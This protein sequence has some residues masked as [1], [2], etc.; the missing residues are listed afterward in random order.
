MLRGTSLHFSSSSLILRN[1]CGGSAPLRR[2]PNQTMTDPIAETRRWIEDAVLG[3]GL[4]PFAT[5]PWSEDAVHFALTDATLL[6]DVVDSALAEVA[7]LIDK[8][9]KQTSFL[10]LREMFAFER[11]VEITHVLDAALAECGADRFFLVA[12][13]HPAYFFEGETG[14]SALTNR[15]PYPMFH[16]IRHADFYAIDERHADAVVEKN[17]ATIENLSD[18]EV[19]RIWMHL[20]K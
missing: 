20:A 1:I 18:D 5:K 19:A 14:R 13:F 8:P 16:F 15:S 11:F 6:Q 7:E 17:R 12:S 10:V 2:Q 3:L 4:C 9:A